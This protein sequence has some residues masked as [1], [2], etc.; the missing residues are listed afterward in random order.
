MG[1]MKPS[2]INYCRLYTRLGY[3][4]EEHSFKEYS[5]AVFAVLFNDYQEYRI[6]ISNGLITIDAK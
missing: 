6:E 1:Y 5:P 2:L 3:F 4:M